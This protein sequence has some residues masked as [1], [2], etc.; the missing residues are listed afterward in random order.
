M[1][2]RQDTHVPPS[3]GRR[4]Q[5]PT[6]LETCIR[7]LHR[8]LAPLGGGAQFAKLVDPIVPDLVE[9]ITSQIQ[10]TVSPYAG[11]PGGRRRRL[12]DM[13]VRGAIL[14]FVA[15]V[16]DPAAAGQGVD[17]LF[18]R[19]GYGDATE[20]TGVNAMGEALEV[21]QRLAWDQVR[22]FTAEHQLSARHLGAVADLLFAYMDHLLRQTRAGYE[23]GLTAKESSRSSTRDELLTLMLDGA[24]T[25]RLRAAAHEAVWPLPDWLAVVA[26]A[27]STAG[28]LPDLSELRE[29]HLVRGTVEPLIVVCRL[30]ELDSVIDQLRTIDGL[31]VARSWGVPAHQVQDAARWCQR[32]ID[33]VGAGVLSGEDVIDCRA[34]RTQLWLHAEPALRQQMAQDLLRPLLAETPNSREILS[35]TLLVWLE[36]R[37][38]APAIAARLGVHPQTVRYRWKRI[39]ELF[40]EVL[41]DPEFIVQITMLLKA[42]VPLWKA[43]DQ[44]DFERYREAGR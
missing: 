21:A 38:S 14:H 42:S 27:S 32:A 18:R 9:E 20:G 41:H 24:A 15:L 16:R 29:R 34:H 40:G 7:A 5:Q 31:W 33:L 26:V 39:N 23:A 13:A 25:P 37:D 4:A 19:M 6:R 2:V 22:S 35:E 30:E 10:E 3:T 12:I 11:M 43:G 44:S 36:T 1:R 17:D 8:E 28:P